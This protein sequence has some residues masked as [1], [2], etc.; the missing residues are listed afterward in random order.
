MRNHFNASVALD[1][2]VYGFD[3]ATLRC[4]DART[5]ERRWAKRRLGKG[6]LIAAD[7]L[8]LVLSERGQLV[9]VEATPE[10]YRELAAHQVLRGRCWTSPSLW[11][12]RLYLRHH[13]ELVCLDL[14]S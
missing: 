4:I 9:L 11:E 8:L 13:S 12:G 6:S 5:G 10:A 7:G 1:G 14:R 2:H 3:A